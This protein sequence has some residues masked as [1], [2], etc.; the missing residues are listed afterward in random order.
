M[1]NH[2]MHLEA[3]HKLVF[4]MPKKKGKESGLP[5]AYLRSHHLKHDMGMP[6]AMTD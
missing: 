3:L 6:M 1:K 4:R 5:K 2:N